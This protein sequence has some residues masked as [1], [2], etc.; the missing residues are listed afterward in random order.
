MPKITIGRSDSDREKYGEKKATAFIGKHLVGDKREAHAANILRMDIARP[1]VISVF[2][3]RGSGKSYT[4]GVIAE[5]LMTAEPDIKDNLATVIVD[6]MGIY[7]SMKYPNDRAT[8]LLDKWDLKPKRVDTDHYI[9]QGQEKI[10]QENEIPYDETFTLQPGGLSAS[11]WAMA[12]DIESNS[13]MGILLERAMRNLKQDKDQDFGIDDVI[14]YVRAQEGFKK[15]V[16]EGLVNRFMSAKDWG[17]FSQTGL[18]LDELT[19]RGK[20]SVLDVSLFGEITGGWS[21]RTLVV[22]LLAKRF[23]RERMRARRIEEIEEME[24]TVRSEMPIVWM[25]MDEAHTFVPAE[26][27]TPASTPILQWVKL[28]REPG[29][30]LALATQRPNK[31]HNDVISQSDLIISHRL[32]SKPDIDALGNVMQTYMRKDLATYLDNL[33]R[34]KGAAICLDDNS[35]RIYSMQVRPRF[36]W[37]AGGTPIAIKRNE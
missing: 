10:F 35:E 28:G 20:V 25:L 2:G 3:K 19:Q 13:P 5:E 16:K 33:P 26:G 34:T 30:S 14:E 12:F 29:V 18:D 1:H 22:G 27:E 15:K 31:L 37:H 32:T 9:P 23:L 21:V 4:L 7:W 17:I 24:G 8:N 36:S 11:D 6:T